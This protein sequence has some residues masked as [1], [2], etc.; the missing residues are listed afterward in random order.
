MNGWTKL[1][2]CL[3]IICIYRYIIENYSFLKRKGIVIQATIEIMLRDIRPFRRV[4]HTD[5]EYNRDCQGPEGW[6]MGHQCLLGD[7]NLFGKVK[8]PWKYMVTMGRQHCG[9]AHLKMGGMVSVVLWHN[10][11]LSCKNFHF[12]VFTGLARESQNLAKV[13]P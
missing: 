2:I 8:A 7:G 4:K 3:S 6:G 5:K 9:I 11:K 1:Y 12:A 10:K 13:I